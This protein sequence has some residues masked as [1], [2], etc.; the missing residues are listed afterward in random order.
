MYGVITPQG[1]IEVSMWE[2]FALVEGRLTFD[3]IMLRRDL[4]NRS[5][6][7]IPY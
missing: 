6:S 3:Q 2:Y 4:I 1:R 7:Y 5:R